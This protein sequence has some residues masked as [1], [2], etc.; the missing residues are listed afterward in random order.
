[1][2]ALRGNVHSLVVLLL[3][4]IYRDFNSLYFWETKAGYKSRVNLPY[5]R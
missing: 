5:W 4:V 3:V 2:K 1:M